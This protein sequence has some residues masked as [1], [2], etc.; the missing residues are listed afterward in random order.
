MNKNIVPNVT[1]NQI[2]SFRSSVEKF[3]NEPRHSKKIF[4]HLDTIKDELDRLEND[5]IPFAIM[6]KMIKE[7][8]NYNVR[9]A[10]L[11]LYCYDV[12]KWKKRNN[13]SSKKT[14]KEN[15]STTS[16]TDDRTSKN[17]DISSMSFDFK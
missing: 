10:D 15:H 5:K 6:C 16:I 4:Y 1:K 7:S 14:L 13:K 12:L 8:F 2:E 3:K 11:R 9:T 17:G